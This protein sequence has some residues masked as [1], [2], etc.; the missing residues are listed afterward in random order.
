MSSEVRLVRL[1][2]KKKQIENKK[3]SCFNA[4]LRSVQI[5]ADFEENNQITKHKHDSF[6]TVVLFDIFCSE[7]DKGTKRVKNRKKRASD[8]DTK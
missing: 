8:D 4:C 1:V 6:F 3:V 7:G 5:G 2:I